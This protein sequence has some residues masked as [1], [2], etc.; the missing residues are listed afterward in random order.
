[1]HGY[2]GDVGRRNNMLMPLVFVVLILEDIL[3]GLLTLL[4]ILLCGKDAVRSAKRW[5]KEV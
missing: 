1:M 3:G 5:V 4:G 2:K